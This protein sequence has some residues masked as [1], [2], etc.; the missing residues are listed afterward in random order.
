MARPP[1]LTSPP[2]PAVT[3]AIGFAAG[4]FTDTGSTVAPDPH[5]R[6]IHHRRLVAAVS[7]L[8]WIHSPLQLGSG[9]DRLI[10]GGRHEAEFR[11]GRSGLDV[12]MRV[13]LLRVAPRDFLSV[14]SGDDHA[15]P[16][17]E[18]GSLIWKC[19]VRPPIKGHAEHCGIVAARADPDRCHSQPRSSL[20]GC[21]RT[22][23]D[24]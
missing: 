21:S 18:A 24:A 14:S 5:R 1:P 4:S 20:V 22:L 2:A 15:F 13:S 6:R 10:V 17:Q 11:S 3:I 12:T 19:T 8:P 23:H 16:R 7:W 9:P